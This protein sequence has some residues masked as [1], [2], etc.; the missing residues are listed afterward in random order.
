MISE[1][2]IPPYPALRNGKARPFLYMIKNRNIVHS[3][4]LLGAFFSSA[5]I[6]PP[7]TKNG[8][9]MHTRTPSLIPVGTEKCR[10]T[11]THR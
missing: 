6:R 3:D 4:P 7:A 9:M 8:T 5:I 10:M 11:G 1:G 2:K